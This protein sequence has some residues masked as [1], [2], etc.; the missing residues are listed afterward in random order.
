MENPAGWADLE[1][2][3]EAG[4]GKAVLAMVAN[5]GANIRAIVCSLR[6]AFQLIYPRKEVFELNSPGC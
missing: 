5:C 4:D 2:L 3:P 6:N 1:K